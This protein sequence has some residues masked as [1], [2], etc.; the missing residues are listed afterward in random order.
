MFHFK[1]FCVVSKQGHITQ[2]EQPPQL[3]ASRKGKKQ[4][5]SSQDCRMLI[6]GWRGM[7]AMSP[8]FQRV[9]GAF[10]SQLYSRRLTLFPLNYYFVESPDQ[11]TQ[12]SSTESAVQ[13]ETEK[14]P[15]C[16]QIISYSGILSEPVLRA[17]CLAWEKFE[18]AAGAAGRTLQPGWV[19]HRCCVLATLLGHHTWMLRQIPV[20]SA[21]PVLPLKENWT[22]KEGIKICY[23]NPL[24]W[25]IRGLGLG[26][27]GHKPSVQTKLQCQQFCWGL[28]YGSAPGTSF[29]LLLKS[30]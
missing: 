11:K 9:W 2:P 6:A 5:H 4:Q 25:V 8:L 26:E 29:R 23:S 24:L 13:E 19:T 7:L 22:S 3:Q 12:A 1:T 15:P 28:L 16:V 21:H 30:I 10:S 20:S 17:L 27:W 14:W 18:S